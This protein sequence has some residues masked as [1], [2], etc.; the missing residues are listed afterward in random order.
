MACTIWGLLSHSCAISA[1]ESNVTKSAVFLVFCARCPDRSKQDAI[2]SR[3]SHSVTYDHNTLMSTI[4]C[5][6]KLDM[7]NLCVFF[8][9]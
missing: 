3:T 2:A 7:L 1:C 4:F 5:F 6:H 8:S 9:F